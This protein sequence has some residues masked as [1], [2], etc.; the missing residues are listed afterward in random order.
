[1]TNIIKILRLNFIQTTY[2]GLITK[3]TKFFIIKELQIYEY[4]LKVSLNEKSLRET[5]NASHF[6]KIN[7]HSFGFA[8]YI[9]TCIY[10]IH[11]H[12]C[13]SLRV[14]HFFNSLE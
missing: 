9:E 12:L 2:V 11:S 6:V 7:K 4:L 14:Y 3:L 8:R 1:M 5:L 10:S 13:S